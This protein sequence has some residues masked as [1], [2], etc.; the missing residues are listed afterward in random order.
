MSG[1][2]ERKKERTRQAISDAAVA[3]F[4]EK[5]FDAVSV[6]EVAAAAEFSRPTLFRAVSGLDVVHARP[7]PESLAAQPS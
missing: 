5:G 6:G 2:R 7:L 3:L 1:L 4:L